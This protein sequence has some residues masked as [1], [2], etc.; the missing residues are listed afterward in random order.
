MYAPDAPRSLISY[1]DLR[2]N[3][4]YVSTAVEND[5]EVLELRRGP[6]RLATAHTAANGLYE[7][8]I[9]QTSPPSKGEEKAGAH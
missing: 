3:D 8:C 1:R 4:I 6:Q 2:V 9:M 5:E 7:F